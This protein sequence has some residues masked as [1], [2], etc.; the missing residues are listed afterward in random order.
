MRPRLDTLPAEQRR[1]WPELSQIPDHFV[2]YGGTAVAL[3]LGGRQSVDFD[4]F[5]NQ[6]VSANVLSRSL[7]FLD[8][9]ELIQSEPNTATFT[10]DRGGPIKVSF[11]GGLTIGR[12][13]RPDR[14]DDNHVRIASLLD[15][16]AQ[17][18]KVI[19][20]RAEPRDYYDIYTLLKAGVTLPEALG[21]TKALY[22]EFNAVLSLKALA[23]YGEPTLASLRT[24]VREYLTEESAKVESVKMIRK[25]ALTISPSVSIRKAH[26]QNRSKGIGI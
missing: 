19:L 22:P 17:K 9:A 15:L 8:G 13:G 18:M 23:Y 7:A 1:L 16:A 24:G 20:V 21:A 11:F 10:V 5:T 4:F 14:C 3:R 6:P 25:I 26:T 2:L 12:I